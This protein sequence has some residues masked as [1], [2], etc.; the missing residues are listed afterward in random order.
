VSE[1]NA[2]HTKCAVCGDKPDADR[3]PPRYTLSLA[4]D[5][6]DEETVTSY[7]FGGSLSVPFACSGDCFSQAEQEGFEQYRDTMGER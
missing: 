2:E 3:F 5:D 7:P 1:S 6:I 4:E